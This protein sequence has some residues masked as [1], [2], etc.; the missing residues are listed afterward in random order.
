MIVVACESHHHH[1]IA[2]IRMAPISYQFPV[3]ALTNQLLE[4]DADVDNISLGDQ[5][6]GQPPKDENPS[7]IN[8]LD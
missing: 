8:F 6:N 1:G 7:E 2:N 3:S 4:F 5:V